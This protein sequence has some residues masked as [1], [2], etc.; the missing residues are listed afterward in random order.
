MNVYDIDRDLIYQRGIYLKGLILLTVFLGAILFGLAYAV[1]SLDIRPWLPLAIMLIVS[2]E[3][4]RRQ[5]IRVGT[6]IYLIGLLIVLSMSLSVYGPNTPIY[7]LMGLPAVLGM[8]LLNRRSFFD[9]AIL[10]CLL[11]FVLTA[12]QTSVVTSI[13]LTFVPCLFCLA[14]TTILYLNASMA[15][16]KVYWA[17]DIQKKDTQR[18]EIFYAQKEELSEAFRLL[19]HSKSLLE[20]S[21]QKLEIAQHRAQEASRAKSLFLSNMSH[22]LRTPLNVVIAYSSSMLEMPQLYNSVALPWQYS[23]DIQLIR[24][25]GYYLLGL[26]NDVLDLSKIEAGKLELHRTTVSLAELFPGILAT[27]TGLVKD[28][29]VQVRPDYEDGDLP[30]VWA[31]PIRVRQILL[32]LI[33]NAI[34]FT[35][36]G[37][38][39]LRVRRE[40]EVVR[41]SVIDTGIGI[42]ET[43]LEHIFDRFEQATHDTDKYYGGTGLGLDISRRLVQM[44]GGELTVQSA[45]GRGSTFTFKLPLSIE[46]RAEPFDLSKSIPTSAKILR[47]AQNIV[48]QSI[49]LVEDEASLR[50]LLHRSLEESGYIV[51]DEQDGVQALAMA[52]GLLPDLIILD[53]RIPSMDGWE[54]LGNLKKDPETAAIPVLL[55][56]ASDDASRAAELGVTMYLRKPFSLDELLA[57]V[58]EIIPRIIET[59]GGE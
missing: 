20:L 11:M 38:V 4:R 39:T 53:I 5:R 42:P 10:S 7:F 8:L 32:N 59:Q 50:D 40:G 35:Q 31:D 26:I 41:L 14:V 28:K 46:Q 55:C 37:S 57:D 36:S 23:R 49:L 19:T 17:T 6:W 48:A 30:L 47:P 54:L 9:L 2:N 21:N 25:S 24:E 56:T 15:L 18:A 44:H 1:A 27:C 33:S 3:F 34:K 51:I 43:A 13:N 22:E 12:L 16:E 52:S 45:E 29:P 58:E